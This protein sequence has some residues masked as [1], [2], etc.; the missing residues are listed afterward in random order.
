MAF[1]RKLYSLL[2]FLNVTF[3]IRYPLFQNRNLD[4]KI[5]MLTHFSRKV[6][7]L[8]FRNGLMHFKL[9]FNFPVA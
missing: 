7:E 1:V 8:C 2:D 3:A 4:R 6:F 9:M 5:I